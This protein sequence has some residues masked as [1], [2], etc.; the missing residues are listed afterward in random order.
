[1]A[2]VLFA[3]LSNSCLAAETVDWPDLIDQSTQTFDDP[4]QDLSYDQIETLKTIVQTRGTLSNGDLSATQTSDL[5]QKIL[6]AVTRMEDAGIDVDWLI[7]QRWIVADLRKAAATTG[8]PAVDG[9]TVT[10][11]GY[12][13]AAPHDNDGRPIAYLVPERGMCSH[14]PPPNANQMIRV[15]V[16]QNWQPRFTHEPVRLTGNLTIAP[17]QEA[18]RIVDG[19]VQM[20]ATFQMEAQI[21]ESLSN[22]KM[23]DN[24]DWVTS[25]AEKLRTTGALPSS[26][27]EISE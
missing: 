18:F 24:N 19:L 25:L 23:P 27:S 14:T 2:F 8:N 10:L 16:T 12:A 9:K 5:E 13:I 6:G 21:I 17:T 22:M 11:V 7:D 20:N 15:H 3:T 26:P 1:M 4:Y